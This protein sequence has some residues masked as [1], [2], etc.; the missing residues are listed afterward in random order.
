MEK[1]K[2]NELFP[3]KQRLLVFFFPFPFL[4]PFHTYFAAKKFEV[5]GKELRDEYYQ[6]LKYGYLFYLAVIIVV[7]ILTRN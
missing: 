2:H 4:I 6:W 3:L 5:G 7:V 1:G